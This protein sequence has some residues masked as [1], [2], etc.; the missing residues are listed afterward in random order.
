MKVAIIGRTG[1]IASIGLECV[2]RGHEV[3]AVVTAKESLETVSAREVIKKFV[4]EIGCGFFLAPNLDQIAD[5][6]KELSPIDIALSVNYPSILKPSHIQLFRL[7]VLNAHGGDLPRY[8]GNACQSWAILNGESSISLCIHKMIGDQLDAGDILM[9]E[10]MPLTDDTY[11]GQIYEWMESRIPEMMVSSA[12][13]LLKNPD[14]VFEQ[15]SSDPNDSLRTY[16]RNKED[17]RIRWSD[18]LPSILRL[19]RASSHPF[20]GAFAYLGKERITIYRAEER[21][22]PPINSVPGQI[23][24]LSD[25]WFD[26]SVEDGSRAIRVTEATTESEIEW[27]EVIR[28]IR[29]RLC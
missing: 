20:S 5:Q 23:L 12:E 11:I 22:Y 10:S 18:Q 25:N 19:I 24:A 27:C 16:P 4:E 14:F 17:G 26:V 1:T 21:V 6:I 9:K 8:R 7:G 13:Q 28:S 15:Q 2:A 3:V 29:D